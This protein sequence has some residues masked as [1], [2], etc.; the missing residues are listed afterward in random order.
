MLTG[1]VFSANQQP[2]AYLKYHRVL[3]ETHGAKSEEV[4]L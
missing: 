1:S 2:D 3:M 4:L